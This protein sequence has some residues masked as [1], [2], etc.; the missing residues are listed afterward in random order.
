LGYT[1]YWRQLRTINL[2]EWAQITADVGTILQ[3]IQQRGGINLGNCN[4]DRGTSPDF[5]PEPNARFAFNGWGDDAHETFAIYRKVSTEKESSECFG[6]GDFCKTARKPYD[7]AVTAVLCYLSTFHL[8]GDIDE[9]RKPIISVSSDGKGSNFLAGLEVARVALPHLGNVLDIP[10]GVMEDDRWV[11][12]WVDRYPHGY[13]FKFCVD[14]Y[15][16]VFRVKDGETF[17]FHTHHLAALWASQHKEKAIV[18]DGMFGRSYEGGASLF[19]P[20]GSFTEKRN[21][22]IVRQQTA[23][24]KQLFDPLYVDAFAK[25][26][27]RGHKPP[28]YVRP[29]EILAVPEMKAYW[30]KDLL[31]EAKAA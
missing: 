4:G 25:Y 6:G 11:G 12:P 28:V 23:A 10:M 31:E 2:A 26:G 24:F 21:K 5:T 8:M 1:H 17:R 29:G 3:H 9:K 14:G 30:L 18:V 20:M 22:A 16:Y 27:E 15:A 13:S 19:Q 7:I